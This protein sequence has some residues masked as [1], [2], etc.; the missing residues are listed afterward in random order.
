M[1][2][3]K[4]LRQKYIEF[5]KAKGH[6]PIPSAS[7][8]PEND[9]S[10]LFVTAGMHPLIPY[11]IGERHPAGTRLVDVQKCIRTGDIDEVGDNRHLTFFEM[12]G[13]W[14]LGDYFKREAIEWSFE[15]LTDKE[16]GLGL[17]P[18]RLYVTVFR[19][20]GNIPK[21]EEAILVWQEVFEKAGMSVTVAGEDEIIKDEVRII[22]L[23]VEDN[24]WIAGASGPCGGDTEMFYDTRPEEGKVG[25]KFTDLVNSYRLMEIWNDV[26]MEF[27]KKPDG[28]VEKLQQQNVDTGMG[29]ERTIVA[30]SGFGNVF[31]TE[32]F[33]PII[34]KIE[35]LSGK[36][37]EDEDDTPLS[38]VADTSPKLGEDINRSM[39]I[40]ADHLRAATFIMG[41]DLGIA[42]SNVDQGYVVR[43]LIR[44][45]IRHG[46]MIG[47][48]ENFTDKI[49][50]VVIEIMGEAYPELGRNRKFIMDN[51]M[52]EEEK[53][54]KTLQEG[55]KVFHESIKTLK[56]ESKNAVDGKSAF[57][58]Y[59]SYG[60]PLELTKELAKENGLEVDEAGFEEEFKK[61]QE[62]SRTAAAGKFK[63]G[64]A[65]HSEKVTAY[66]T[67][68]H[69]LNAALRQVLGEHVF[70]KGSNITE[71]RLRFDFS[72]PE[73][74]TPEQIK[75][76]EDLVNEIIQKNV[77]VECAEM[78]AEEA[79][80][81]GAI[82]VF[83]DKYGEKVKVYSVG[84]GDIC[85]SKEICGGPHVSNTKELGHFRIIKEEASSA[86]VRRIK[87]VLE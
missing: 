10:T 59:Q 61:H 54:G 1:I 13:N 73:K 84:G 26:F 36:K 14:S 74:M 15:F 12:L 40:I 44:R 64:L 23:G 27:N 53:F 71:E 35:E 20:E 57:D 41:D 29:V 16:K 32:L 83:A 72:H 69:L 6:T 21:D 50:I 5:F 7:L 49:A 77:A 55:L 18:K 39:R 79:K 63:G 48:Q 42:P 22:P 31:E 86:G 52:G 68:T 80:A 65:D 60:F 81:R 62:L 4:E 51:L 3:A 34:Q 47:I 24:F 37:Y 30:L 25:G 45:A 75:Q 43:K 11:L 87:A 33:Q 70:Q 67:A 46:R 85:F 19:G 58:L 66:H 28:A 76:V 9:P 2:T 38:A 82:G 56:H 17:D 78:T 8:M